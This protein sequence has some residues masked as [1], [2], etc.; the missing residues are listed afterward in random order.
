MQ[1]V[2]VGAPKGKGEQIARI[3][4]E[5]GLTEATISQV[6]MFEAEGVTEQ[7]EIKVSVAAPDAARFVEAF[8][9]APFFDPLEYSIVCD[10]VTAI[11]SR[12]TPENVARPMKLSSVTVL[13]DLWIQ[14]HITPAFIARAA[15]SAFL[16]A[17]GLMEADMTTLIIALLFA[18][19]LSQVKH[20]AGAL[21]GNHAH[22]VIELFAAVAAQRAEHIACEAFG[23]NADQ[24]VMQ[25]G[26]VASNQSQVFLIVGVVGIQ[27]ELKLAVCSGNARAF[28]AHHLIHISP[29]QTN[30]VQPCLASTT[31][32]TIRTSSMALSM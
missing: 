29:N 19:F 18:P 8:M 25:A 22:G 12:E 6:R 9:A 1:E 4:L 24:D 2:T 7:E 14:N 27:A 15:V 28:H 16:L 13:Q 3:A 20:N 32:N 30:P 31:S 21:V 5:Q 10:E 26:D 23:M 11:V 17:Y